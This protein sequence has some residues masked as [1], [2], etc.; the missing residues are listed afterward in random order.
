MS[1]YLLIA[2]ALCIFLH[3]AV[4]QEWE[5]YTTYSYSDDFGFC[6]RECLNELDNGN[7]AVSSSISYKSGAGDFYA[8]HPAVAIVSSEGYELAR[9]DFFRPGYCTTSN[10]PYLFEKDEELYMLT[11]YSPDHDST[12][13]N[14]FGDCDNPP[15]EAILGL[16]K[17]DANLNIIESYEHT[18]PIDIYEQRDKIEWQLFPNEYSG[19]IFLFSAFEDEGNI[20]GAYFKN[21]S[22]A[23]QPRGHD[24]L[25]FFKM[26][27][28]GNFLLRKG[29]EMNTTG[30]PSQLS[31]KRQQIVKNNEGYLLYARHLGESMDDP[32]NGDIKYYDNNFNHIAT[33]YMIQPEQGIIPADLD[34]ISVIRSNQNTTYLSTMMRRNP[35]DKDDIRLYEIDDDMNNSEELLPI[36]RYITRYTHDFDDACLVGID[37][38]SDCNI[39]FAYTLNTGFGDGE[40]SWIMI[41]KLNSDFDTISTFFLDEINTFSKATSIKTT[42]DGGLVLV[43]ES[44][45]LNDPNV[46]LTRIAKF[47]ASA[48]LNIEEAHAHNLKL[49]VAYPNPGGDVMNIRTGLRNAI[50]SVYDM[51]GR[52]I[53]E[54]EITDDI[55]S[56]YDSIWK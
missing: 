48:F 9:N 56:I 52:K 39:Y 44:Y 29:Y 21:V 17:L 36:C 33:R 43:Y 11:T 18:Y 35:D 10:Y 4:A 32:Y 42:K 50:L 45:K 12:Y 7:F 28:E 47:P 40:D 34:C 23:D 31:Y 55:T 41:E 27:F 53:H 46:R 16:Y 30:G 8:A 2:T 51:Q 24:T 26:D 15:T 20:T 49:A 6:Y 19:N 5:V 22:V 25:F 3:N 38:T 37:K 1:R 13:F 14:Y 54:Q